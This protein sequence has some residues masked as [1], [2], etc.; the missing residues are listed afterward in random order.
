[1]NEN[2]TQV[3]KHNVVISQSCR[4]FLSF[5]LRITCYGSV[6]AQTSDP[7]GE[8]FFHFHRLNYILSGHP[9]VFVDDRRI[10]L[11][12]GNL[13]YLPPNRM[14][15]IDEG[16]KPVELL[17]VNFE[18]GALDMM[19]KMRTFM[20][21]LFPDCYVHDQDGELLEILQIIQQ[22]GAKNQIGIGLEIQNLFENLFIHAVR[23]SQRYANLRD[24]AVVSGGNNLINEA[25]NYINDHL[26]Y[27]FRLSEMA[28]ALNISE[29]YLYKIF[30]TKTGK[31]PAAF[32]QQLRMETAKQAL[33]NQSL[34]IK[35]IASHLGY[36]DVSHFS[37]VFKRT[38][39]MS[40]RAYRNYL[41][42]NHHRD[43]K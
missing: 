11:Q 33:A 43:E 24:D 25:M 23:L 38:W 32:I 10:Q 31:S 41:T 2:T 35:T 3:I 20:A 12:P 21:E 18:V 9:R 15:E 39:G 4:Y 42:Q 29:N 13:V 27:N 22:V 7:G 30:M 6:R 19:D 5:A 1:M 36:G 34:P 16:G 26:G 37:T 14:L 28:D 40:P 17:F 8:H